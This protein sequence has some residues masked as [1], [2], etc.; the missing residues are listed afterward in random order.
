MAEVTPADIDKLIKEVNEG[1]D[2]DAVDVVEFGL[3]AIS[4][5]TEAD[6]VE[7]ARVAGL[8]LEIVT[9]DPEADYPRD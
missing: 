2:L 7:R 3:K 6:A 5:L 1:P 8:G 4:Y 9:F